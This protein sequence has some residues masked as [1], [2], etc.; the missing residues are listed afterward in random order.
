MTFK[1]IFDSIFDLA[2]ALFA[3]I[4]FSILIE[5]FILSV[6]YSLSKTPHFNLAITLI[7]IAFQYKRIRIWQWEI[8][9]GKI[10]FQLL[11]VS[12][13]MAFII[14]IFG[15]GRPHVLL[16]VA[17]VLLT[18]LPILIFFCA[19]NICSKFF[20]ES[21]FVKQVQDMVISARR[22]GLFD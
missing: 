21:N 6:V 19:Y 8:L 9:A 15:Y 16:M 11:M 2:L 12:F 1:K 7:I 17:V 10:V 20:P 18:F 13:F 4:V 14:G 3:S 22:V 5:I